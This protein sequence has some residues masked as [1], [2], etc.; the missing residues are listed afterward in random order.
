MATILKFQA[1]GAVEANTFVELDVSNN[2][3][4]QTVSTSI[5]TVGVQLNPTFFAG[6][7]AYVCVEG[8]CQVRVGSTGP[9]L[10]PNTMVSSD[11][12]VGSEGRAQIGLSGD[13]ALGVFYGELSGGAYTTVA[14]DDLVTIRLLSNKTTLIA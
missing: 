14:A 3:A 12:A 6:D 4:T 10:T 13:A 11:T 8:E 7:A 5:T 1:S 2:T 9:A